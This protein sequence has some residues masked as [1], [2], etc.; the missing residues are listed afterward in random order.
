M[1]SE[2]ETK[3]GIRNFQSSG[4]DGDGNEE[5]LDSKERASC[6]PGRDTFVCLT[7]LG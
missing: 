5:T 4:K 1:K 3:M 6:L 7:N 2:L